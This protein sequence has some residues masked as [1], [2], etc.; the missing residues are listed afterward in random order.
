MTH[1]QALNNIEQALNLA[2]QKGAFSLA[3]TQI[4]IQSLLFLKDEAGGDKLP[5]HTQAQ[6]AGKA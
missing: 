1:E 3:E 5:G 4:I 6:A 2:T